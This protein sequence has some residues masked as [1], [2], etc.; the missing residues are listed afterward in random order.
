MDA[1]PAS[2]PSTS[3]TAR[4]ERASRP[5]KVNWICACTLS[6]PSRTST[7]FG[8][9]LRAVGVDPRDRQL[10]GV[11][12]RR[13]RGDEPHLCVGAADDQ[14]GLCRHRDVAH[15]E[16]VGGHPPGL[17]QV[18]AGGGRTSGDDQS[19]RDADPAE[20]S[21]GP[22]RPEGVVVV[23]LR[24]RFRDPLP[25]RAGETVESSWRMPRR[26]STRSC[27]SGRSCG[28]SVRLASSTSARATAAAATGRRRRAGAGP[29]RGCGGPAWRSRRRPTTGR[30]RSWP[31]PR[32]RR[33]R[34]AGPVRQ[35][36]R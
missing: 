17:E 31:A 4:P 33:S 18:R 27:G 13:D 5:R 8:W 2:S 25:R 35:E 30:A 11:A 19:Q 28:R 10:A 1:D 24:L 34:P 21:R 12:V 20:P 14:A 29:R 3:T 7:V 32:T 9:R 16:S 15:L 22:R 6:W 26:T 23:R 36:A